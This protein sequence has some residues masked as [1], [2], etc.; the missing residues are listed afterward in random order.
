MNSY[1]KDN[2]LKYRDIYYTFRDYINKFYIDDIMSNIYDIKHI[3]YIFNDLVVNIPYLIEKN[4]YLILKEKYFVLD[5]LLKD[6]KL[7]LDNVFTIKNFK[8]FCYKLY[9]IKKAFEIEEL[10]F[11]F[12]NKYKYYIPYHHID[13]YRNKDFLELINSWCYDIKKILPSNFSI[14][15]L[16]YSISIENFTEYIYNI[17]QT[18]YR[19]GNINLVNLISLIFQNVKNITT[20]THTYKTYRTSK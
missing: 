6:L 9:V 4:N 17:E 1:L 2:H 8:Q 10:I 12:I 18:E 13:Y 11:L 14:I 5:N 19:K 15:K 20:Y 16:E 7:Y 3:V